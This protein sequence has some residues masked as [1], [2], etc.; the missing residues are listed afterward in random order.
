MLASANLAVTSRRPRGLLAAALLALLACVSPRPLAAQ[1]AQPPGQPDPYTATVT[2]DATA[3]SVA[4]A[5]DMARLDGARRALA[6]VIE[7]LAGGSDKA[8]PLKLGDNEITDMVASFEVANEKMSAVRYTADYTYHFKRNDV[9][10]AMQNAGI[11]MAAGPAGGSANPSQA[12][13][14]K[15]VVVLPIYQDGGGDALLWD[16]P[17]PW[18]DAW[19][20]RSPTPGG[21]TML[22]PLGDVSDLSAIDADKARTGDATALAAIAKKE[23][24]D[25]V[26]VMVAAQRAGTKPGLDVTVKRYHLGQFVDVHAESIDGNPGASDADLL[27]RG[28]DT[29][30]ADIDSGWKN[31][32]APPAGPLATLTVTAPITGLDDWLKLRDQLTAL[33][34]V[35][36]IDVK[37]LSRQEATIDI[38]YVGGMDQLKASLA[39]LRID[40]QGGDPIWR[41]ARSGADKP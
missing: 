30:A 31:A 4:K 35:R 17:N 37:S 3:D 24:V 28:A 40:L 5:R 41:L 12:A 9:T 33:P 27:R 34:S 8:K 13:P 20:S 18:R 1:Q 7:K 15:S 2:V 26:L 14:A 32:K 11:A 16:D 10:K 6:A 38:Q 29:I 19:S 21:T 22:V 25:D 39:T 23:G 36:K